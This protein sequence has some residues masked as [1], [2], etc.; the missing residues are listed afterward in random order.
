MTGPGTPDTVAAMVHVRRALFLALSL[1]SACAATEASPDQAFRRADDTPTG[2][3]GHFLAGR[4]ALTETDPEIAAKEL[5]RAYAMAPEEP[6]L[7][8][9]AFI[10]SIAAERPEALVLARA[11]PDNMA[12]QLLLAGDALQAGR[13]AEAER[14]FHA[15]PRE[16]LSQ[17][18]QPLLVAWAQQGAGH[19]DAALQT[20][21]PF[22]DNPRLRG[23]YTLHAGLI[24]EASNR[25]VEAARHFQG[26]IQDPPDGDLRLA[27]IL[28]SWHERNNRPAEARRLLAGV[29][30]R[31]PEAGIALRDLLAAVG[32]RPV[33]TPADAVAEAYVALALAL[34]AQDQNDAA[35]LML[36]MA[37]RMRPD[38]AL[39]RIMEADIQSAR[40][41]YDLA[42]KAV[43]S[44]GPADPL[45]AMAR[46]RRAAILDRMDRRDD[47]IEA[48]RQIAADHPESRL[49]DLQ[50]GDLLR[51]QK[52]YPEAIA[53]YSRAIARIDTPVRS[54]W[55]A[56]YQRGV[57][58][59]RSNRWALAEADLKMALELAPGQPFVLNYLGYSWADMGRNLD[60][61][62]AMIQQAA[63]DRKDDGAV[64]DSL[65]WVMFRQGD[66]AN[67]VRT[68][69]RAVELEPQDAT[70]TEHLGDAYFV[71]GRKIEA[72]YQ[73][74][75][76]LTLS[77]AIEDVAKLEDKLKNGL[78][79]VAAGNRQTP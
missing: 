40:K 67:A 61:A 8:Q 70:I 11:M 21:R 77:P 13:W 5:L 56:F 14:R 12:A 44:I 6:E 39:G 10:A 45:I 26:L 1:L 63:V 15:L 43:D 65:G 59:E 30:D 73:W 52:R 69:E 24:A 53:A 32:A 50:L 34:R 79:G 35:L 48:L 23:I 2:A 71:A 20:L 51:F 42:L 55:L 75:R 25:P 62:R 7:L 78:A 60:Q 36:R 16:G 18:L 38:F 49:P 47:A 46:L 33:N 57:A 58:Y 37:F 22:I 27:Q 31:S 68:L 29:A 9:Q 41:H 72:R 4:F 19:I 3:F 17:L 66:V 54:D 28:A 76:A 74:K 64:A